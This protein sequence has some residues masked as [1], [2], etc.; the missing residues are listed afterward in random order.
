MVDQ[1]TIG[2]EVKRHLTI[3]SIAVTL[4]ISSPKEPQK[5]TKTPNK[6]ILRE[7]KLS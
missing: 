4:C 3:N 7:T 2:R 1:T 5:T 6:K